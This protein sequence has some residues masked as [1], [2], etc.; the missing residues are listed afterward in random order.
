[1]VNL[2]GSLIMITASAAIALWFLH[3]NYSIVN[4]PL[5]EPL[6]AKTGSFRM[7]PVSLNA[8]Y[9]HTVQV[10]L[11]T[12]RPWNDL[13]CVTGAKIQPTQPTVCAGRAP[14]LDLDWTVSENNRV[15][16]TGSTSK[17]TYLTN[18]G[19]VAIRNLGFFKGVSGHTYVL[20][21]VIRGNPRNLT[22]LRPRLQIQ[23]ASAY[24]QVYGLL[25][26]ILL[27]VCG[28]TFLLGVVGLVFAF[29]RRS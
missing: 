24:G 23:L 28:A 2:P 6:P 12:I 19:K 18:E 8:T 22:V 9:G 4:Y 17:S 1:M 25:S 16:A 3:W 13:L 27:L 21:V 11:D 5:D 15:V 14:D 10:S 20:D 26:P 29:I 7:P